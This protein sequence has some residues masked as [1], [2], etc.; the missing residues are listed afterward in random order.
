MRHDAQAAAS[1]R[2]F[3]I[4]RAEAEC[5]EFLIAAIS[6]AFLIGLLMQGKSH[7][8]EMSWE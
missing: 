5:V 7:F 3:A 1:F 6:T 4:V 2:F 8:K